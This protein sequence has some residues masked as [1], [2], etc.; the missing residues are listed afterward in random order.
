LRLRG[1]KLL[2]V[3]RLLL[4]LLLLLLL[5]VR[6]PVLRTRLGRAR[7]MRVGRG[8]MGAKGVGDVERLR[9]GRP[10][11]RANSRERIASASRPSRRCEVSS[12]R[13]SVRR[14]G[15]P[16]A[17]RRSSDATLRWRLHHR[18]DRRWRRW[19]GRGLRARSERGGGG[20]PK[21]LLRLAVRGAVW[22]RRRAR[23]RH[24]WQRNRTR[25]RPC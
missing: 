23:R 13:E 10:T 22:I 14:R 2:R 11:S 8:R 15:R 21:A 7:P 24:S 3:R 20:A 9:T 1:A 17:R 19:P 16:L 25:C 12:R 6:E 18:R 5:R 4:L